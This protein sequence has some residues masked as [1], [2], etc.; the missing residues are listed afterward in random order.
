MY[1][2]RVGLHTLISKFAVVA[3]SPEEPIKQ[4]ARWVSE[5]G[6]TFW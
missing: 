5:P 1:V 3:L 4:E 2:G 6:W